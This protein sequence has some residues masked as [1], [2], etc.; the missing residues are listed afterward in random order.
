MGHGV[1]F[2]L[3]RINNKRLNQ[4]NFFLDADYMFLTGTLG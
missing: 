1:V 3:S 2:L 4:G